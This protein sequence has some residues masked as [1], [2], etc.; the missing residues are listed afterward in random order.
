MGEY[1]DNIFTDEMLESQ[2]FINEV[3]SVL[4]DITGFTENKEDTVQTEQIDPL[5]K[6]FKKEKIE[7][8]KIEKKINEL[9]NE[10]KVK[11]LRKPRTKA[12][13]AIDEDGDII[14]KSWGNYYIEGGEFDEET[15][16]MINEYLE[17]CKKPLKD[18]NFDS[19]IVGKKNIIEK[20]NDMNLHR[21]KIKEDE[22]LDN[23][24]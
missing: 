5:E 15:V 12:S 23:V 17:E 14:C 7:V 21:G 11:Y 4:S 3:S 24:I 2:E 9:S 20:F 19:F 8:T 16:L 10:D 13:I 18:R 22:F 1:L 6:V